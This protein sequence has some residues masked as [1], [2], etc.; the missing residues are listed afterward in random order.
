MS[1]SKGAE[2]MRRQ[3]AAIERAGMTRQLPSF[4]IGDTVKVAFRV[5]EGDK[6]R[7]QHFEGVVIARGGSGVRRAFT[8]RRVAFGEGVERVFPL[9]SSHLEGVEVVRKGKVRRAKL[10]YLRKTVG[11]H[12][13]VEE[14]RGEG[15][16]DSQT[17]PEPAAQAAAD[18]PDSGR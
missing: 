13:R 6:T 8:V 14:R 1:L 4:G 5:Q 9:Y 2:E 18:H 3:I 17:A 12:S 15:A 16:G 10:Y 11:R 7:I